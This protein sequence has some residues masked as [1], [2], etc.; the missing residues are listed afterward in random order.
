MSALAGCIGSGGNEFGAASD[1]WSQETSQET[2]YGH[3]SKGVVTL[4][5]N[6]YAALSTNQQTNFRIEI[7]AN[8]GSPMDFFV[9]DDVEFDRFRDQK[10]FRIYEG[11]GASG[12]SNP[13]LS[14]R[15]SPGE[16]HVVFDNTDSTGVEANGT[17]EANYTVR[18]SL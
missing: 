12:E 17:V 7:S 8:A 13:I 11:L 16:Y 4:P 15:L 18:T 14:N 10:E 2:E 1:P 9:V 3:V 5:P 6:R